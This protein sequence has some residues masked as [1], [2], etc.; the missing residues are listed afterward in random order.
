MRDGFR[1]VRIWHHWVPSEASQLGVYRKTTG[2]SIV[3]VA[4][5]LLLNPHVTLRKAEAAIESRL[6]L[7]PKSGKPDLGASAAEGLVLE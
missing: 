4:P 2:S 1:I 7:N 5:L 3:L 6:T